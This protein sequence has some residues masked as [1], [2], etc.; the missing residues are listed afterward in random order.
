[1]P[2]SRFVQAKQKELATLR[3]MKEIPPAYPGTKP[4]FAKALLAQGGGAVI[5]E[6]K[7]AS[8]SKGEIN[9]GMG[10]EQVGRMYAR[11]G[12]TAISVLTEET[13]FKGDC[14]YLES[15]APTGIPLLRKD[16]ITDPLQ[17]AFT[18]STPA[19]AILI[20]VRLFE[21]DRKLQDILAACATHGL[22]PVVEAFDI[23]DLERAQNAGAEIIQINNRDLATLDIDMNRSFDL[24]KKKQPNEMWISAS[25]ITTP[26][27]G[28]TIIHA[29]F[30]ALLIGTALMQEGDPGE[31][32][33]GFTR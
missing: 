5:A 24:I 8:P 27:M 22:E 18:A 2:L 6:Y 15:M 29:G 10:P 23:R 16:F 21:T 25:G 33:A 26:E 30:D 3:S 20:I 11:A 4:G 31:M 9:M 13:Y 14:A 17:V 1:M 19:S 7:R 32:L 12:A 28:Q